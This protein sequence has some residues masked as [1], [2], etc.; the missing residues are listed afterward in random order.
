MH[1]RRPFSPQRQSDPPPRLTA[2]QRQAWLLRQRAADL[3][4]NAASLTAAGDAET[5]QDLLVHARQL[6]DRASR[7]EQGHVDD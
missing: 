2:L 7:I 5:H 6:E 1:P 3:R 4:R